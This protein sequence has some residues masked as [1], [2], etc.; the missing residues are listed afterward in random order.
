MDRRTVEAA[1]ASLQSFLSD[2]DPTDAALRGEC[3]T[4]LT[5]L[6]SAYR[7]DPSAFSPESIEALKELS[8]LLRESASETS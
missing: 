6:R 5:A 3:E 8:D 2:G 4:V 7:A 1:V